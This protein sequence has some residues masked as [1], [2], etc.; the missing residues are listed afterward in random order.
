[1]IADWM[2]EVGEAV[3][4]W[5]IPGSLAAWWADKRRMCEEKGQDEFSLDPM[6]F[7]RCVAQ[8]C[9][10]SAICKSVLVPSDTVVTSGRSEEPSVGSSYLGTQP[11][12]RRCK[13]DSEWTPHSVLE[14]HLCT[15]CRLVHRR[16]ASCRA[17]CGFP[18]KY[19]LTVC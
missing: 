10:K 3:G 6:E 2:W 15:V 16:L 19:D 4:P 14:L 7:E 9:E 13:R 12:G 11:Y 18:L 17:T 1:M 5:V 8:P